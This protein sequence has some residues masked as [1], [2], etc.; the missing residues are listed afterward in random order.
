MFTHLGN[1]SK[2][3]TLDLSDMFLPNVTINMLGM[4]GQLVDLDL[5]DSSIEEIDSNLWSKLRRLERLNL[6]NNDL[7]RLKNLTPLKEL[8]KLH[9]SHNQLQEVV[10]HRLYNLDLIDLSYNKIR[11]LPAS[12]M[13]RTDIVMKVNLSQK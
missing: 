12:W 11:S 3:R 6:M 2:L 5:S 4:L 8:Q 1:D 10:V 7:R 9:L 13:A